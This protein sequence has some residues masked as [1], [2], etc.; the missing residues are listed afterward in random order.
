ML[1]DILNGKEFYARDA[2]FYRDITK[3]GRKF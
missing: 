2:M 1:Q 3:F